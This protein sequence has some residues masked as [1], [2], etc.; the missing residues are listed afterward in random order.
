[1]KAKE[2]ELEK[3][4]SKLKDLLQKVPGQV[5]WDVSEYTNKAHVVPAVDFQKVFDGTAS[6]DEIQK[7]GNIRGKKLPNQIPKVKNTVIKV[8]DLE[9]TK[10]KMPG[11]VTEGANSIIYESVGR[12]NLI[13]FDWIEGTGSTKGKWVGKKMQK[14][15]KVAILREKIDNTAEQGQIVHLEPIL[16]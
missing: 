12:R 15:I 16:D 3:N 14:R 5:F 7:L 8:G 1:M 4:K 13:Q 10:F 9:R 6:E 11:K 2:G